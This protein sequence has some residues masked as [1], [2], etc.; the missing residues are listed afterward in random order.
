MQKTSKFQDKV[1]TAINRK[2]IYDFIL[3]QIWAPIYIRKIPFFFLIKKT[4]DT[5]FTQLF[6]V[7]LLYNL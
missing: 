4:G 5:V 2:N 1:M 6:L 7:W 3:G